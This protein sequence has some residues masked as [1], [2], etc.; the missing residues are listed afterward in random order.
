MTVILFGVDSPL[1]TLFHKK[2]NNIMMT[3]I[4]TKKP[5]LIA[6][7]LMSW[8]PMKAQLELLLNNDFDNNLDNWELWETDTHGTVDIDST[9]QLHGDKS[10]HIQITTTGGGAGWELGFAQGLPD[11]LKGNTTYYVSFLAKASQNASIDL[12]IQETE[13]PW[14]NLFTK[15]VTLTTTPQIYQDTFVLSTD[16]AC[17]FVFQL[18][19]IGD[20]EIWIDD[21]HLLEGNN[22]EEP[23]VSPG[24]KLTN[25]FF[26]FQLTDWQLWENPTY[27]QAAI[28]DSG[29]LEGPN[30]VKINITTAGSG[31]AWELGLAQAIDGGVESGKT[32]I[33]SCQAK[34]SEETTIEMVVQQSNSPWGAVFSSTLNLTTAPQTFTETFVAAA[35]EDV[36]FVFQMGSIGNATVWVDDV[37]LIDTSVDGIREILP[38]VTTTVTPNPF[39]DI[40]TIGFELPKGQNVNIAVYDLR[41]ELV[42]PV[43]EKD[44]PAGKNNFSVDMTGQPAGVY[45]CQIKT[46]T[47]IKTVRLVLN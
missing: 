34:A 28:D 30:S 31:E 36:N 39:D 35:D 2:N 13:E 19:A 37:H 40:T 15:A 16:A 47:G 46:I 27:G 29:V 24:E 32:Y 9:A 10:A 43:V 41:G 18:G 33:V 21:V 7:V 25:N 42:K 8:L 20:A 45:F 1:F 22:V 4:F 5:A 44:F 11:G 23:E 17:N 12:V 26:N 6:I 3:K 14:D 38:P